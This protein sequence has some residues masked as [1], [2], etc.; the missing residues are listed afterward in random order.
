MLDIHFLASLELTILCQ[1]G[2]EFVLRKSNS[3]IV[4]SSFTDKIHR[5][6]LPHLK[7]KSYG[8]PFKIGRLFLKCKEIASE[9]TKSLLVPEL[10]SKIRG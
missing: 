5:R 8:T 6:K 4:S 3:S 9:K 10:D 7:T 2:L 1:N